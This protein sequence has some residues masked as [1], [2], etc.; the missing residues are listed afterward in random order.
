MNKARLSTRISTRINIDCAILA[1]AAGL[2]AGCASAPPAA[3]STAAVAPYAS[4]VELDGRLSVN[5]LRAGKQESISGK[6]AW[7][8][9]EARTDVTLASPLGQ[10]IATIAVT[11]GA[12]TLKEGNN[13]PRTASDVDTL[14]AQVL[15]WPLP[16]S[17]L[18]DWLQGYAVAADGQRFA[19]SPAQPKV[20]T[21]DGW[22]LEFVSWQEGAAPPRPRRIDARRGATGD[23][24][25]I[26]IRIVVDGAA[27][28]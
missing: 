3:L 12:V 17:G 20:T 14:T 15:G 28:P 5:Y 23:I 4:K 19:A 6:F 13:P 7:R 26:D 9:S 16:V 10:T 27:A 25:N 21:R 24:E 1:C 22:E 18:R 11:P 2:L 8:Q